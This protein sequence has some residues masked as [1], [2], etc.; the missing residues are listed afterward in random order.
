MTDNVRQRFEIVSQCTPDKLVQNHQLIE[1]FPETIDNTMVQT[2]LACE[3][4][5]LYNYLYCRAGSSSNIHLIAGAAFAEA[6]D[7]Y[8]KSYFEKGL[9]HTESLDAGLL[10]LVQKYGWHGSLEDSAEWQASNKSFFRIAA[11]FLDYWEEYHP[12][13]GRAKVWKT[14]EGEVASEI[15]GTIELEV[16]HPVTGLPLLFSYRL[17]VIETR[18]GQVWMVDD[19]TTGSLGASWANSWATRSQFMGYLYA[20]QL[21]GYPVVGM[22]ARGTGILKTKISHLEAPVTFD[23]II[24]KRWWHWINQQAA[25]MVGLT[26][27]NDRNNFSYNFGDQCNAYS[28]CAFKDVC[29]S[30]F[31]HKVLNTMPIRIWNP[32][33][34]E[35]SPSCEGYQT[36][37]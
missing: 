11:A 12:K 30:R 28:G 17:D 16:K 26:V 35:E 23:P 6:N 15:G 18:D 9:S 4:K 27:Q 34:P 24:V 21:R 25:R 14:P 22:I 29:I 19:K 8:R 13:L 33:C 7:V 37:G 36:N 1:L 31:S 2:F 32:E 10:A 3:K 5:F 20:C